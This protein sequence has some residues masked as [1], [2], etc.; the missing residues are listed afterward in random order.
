M[1]NFTPIP[2]QSGKRRR[3][4][5]KFKAMIIELCQQPEHS[6][7]QIAQDYNLNANLVHKWLYRARKLGEVTTYPGFLPVPL[8]AV[9]ATSSDQSLPE[10][11]PESVTISIASR[12]GQVSI[13]WPATQT[14]QS[15][16]WLKALLS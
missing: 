3:F 10:T 13:R 4:D 5:P 14:D 2:A 7:A 11:P 12:F 1:T 9:A 15:A 6:V 16:A 8:D